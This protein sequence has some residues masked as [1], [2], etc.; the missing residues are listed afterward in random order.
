MEEIEL[1][2]SFEQQTICCNNCNKKIWNYAVVAPNEPVTHAFSVT[3]PFCNS[4]TDVFRIEGLM[5]AG[6]VGEDQS[7][8]PTTIVDMVLDEQNIW[9][10]KLG[11]K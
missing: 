2:S 10:I 5:S 1:A 4:D 6:P 11:K 7:K 8:Y 3:C 9:R